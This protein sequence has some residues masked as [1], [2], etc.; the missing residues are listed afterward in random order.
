MVSINTVLNRNLRKTKDFSAIKGHVFRKHGKRPFDQYEQDRVVM[1]MD[2]PP[3]MDG[4]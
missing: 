3:R 1:V 2:P 4:T